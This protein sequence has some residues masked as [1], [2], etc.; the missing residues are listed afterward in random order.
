[1][2]EGRRD[3]GLREGGEERWRDVRRDR[4]MGGE[5]EGCVREGRRGGGMCEGGG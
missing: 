4:E 2:R 3:G 5:V 1:M